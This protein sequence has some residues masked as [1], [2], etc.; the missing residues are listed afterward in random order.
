MYPQYPYYGYK[1]EVKRVP[2]SFPPQHQNFRPGLE[3]IMVPR[4][5]SENPS[6][7]SG[8]KLYNKVAIITGGDSG[9]GRATAIVFA[10][11]GANIAIVYLNEH[12]DAAETKQR[13]EN[14]GR[15]CLTIS[16]DLRKEDTSQ[17]VIKQTIDKFGKLDILVNNV[18]TGYIT[19]NI[20][21]ISSEQLEEIFSTNIFSFFHM[22]KAALP[23]LKSGSSIINTSSIA[24]FQGYEFS[25][26]YAASKGAI[27]T[28]TR[29]LSLSLIQQGIRVNN[30]AP[31]PVWTPLIPSSYS[32]EQ[33]SEH[34][35]NTPMKR[36]AQPFELAPAYVYLASDDSRYVSGQTIHVNGGVILN[37]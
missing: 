33:A 20:L 7:Q 32:A 27:V 34:G 8:D 6:Y 23:Y 4:P 26:D 13:V 12:R 21:D 15:Q 1:E 36:A 5:I 35:V 14:L 17:Q 11:E 3:Y 9:I 16:G 28:F 19:H 30:V 2:I 31:G 18:G 10:K 22:T 37:T 24:N 25:I 29:S